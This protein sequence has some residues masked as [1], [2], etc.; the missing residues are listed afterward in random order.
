[1]TGA[2]ASPRQDRV[3]GIRV[4]PLNRRRI[5]NFK[6]NRRGYWSAWIFAVLFVLSLF[7]ELIANDR[8]LFVWYDG[9]PYI[10]ASS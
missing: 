7:A 10:P 2:I 9:A 8:P 3:L 6:A 5:E 4:T 1:M